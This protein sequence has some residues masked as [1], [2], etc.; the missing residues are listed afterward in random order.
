MAETIGEIQEAYVAELRRVAPYLNVW[1]RHLF[2]GENDEENVW[3]RW[4][5]GPSGHPRVIAIFRKY[6]F[7][8]EELN[9][10][11]RKNFSGDSVQD[12]ETMWGRD[13]FGDAPQF[14]RHAD[15]LIGDIG[16]IAPDLAE[17][18]NGLCFLPIA[19]NQS[20]ELV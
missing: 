5:T 1:W 10:N 15:R 19:V 3:R 18:V 8:I 11:V 16:T 17:L 13:D 12:L 14:F 9:E 2:E 20:E 7:K 6:Y 4:P